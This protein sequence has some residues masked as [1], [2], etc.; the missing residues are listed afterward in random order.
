MNEIDDERQ[1]KPRKKPAPNDAWLNRRGNRAKTYKVIPITPEQVSALI[2]ER[3]RTK[4][5]SAAFIAH[6]D[7]LPDGLTAPAIERWT[8]GASPTAPEGHFNYV[9]DRYRSLPTP[10]AH[11]RAPLQAGR[12]LITDE[13]LELLESELD[14][15]GAPLTHLVRIRSPEAFKLTASR[16]SNWRKRRA[17]KANKAEWDYVLEALRNIPDRRS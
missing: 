12:I 7:D 13:M 2:T 3:E 4:V 15:T 10:P 14:R 5:G 17:I 8:N 16:I 11:V 6:F 9:L 1:A